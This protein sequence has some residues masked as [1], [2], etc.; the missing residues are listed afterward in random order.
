MPRLGNLVQQDWVQ[1]IGW[2][3][4]HSLWQHGFIVLLCALLLWLTRQGSA[5]LRYLIALVSLISAVIVSIL[6]FLKYQHAS[7]TIMLPALPLSASTSVLNPLAIFSPARINNFYLGLVTGTWILGV[8]V[9]GIKSGLAYSYCQGLKQRAS[10][11]IPH[12]W[13]TLFR[14]L[15][16]QVGVE[17]RAALAVSTEVSNPCVIGHLKPL[18]LLPMGLLT[19]LR[20]EQIEMILLHELAHIRRQDYLVGVA[21]VLIKNLFFFNPFIYWLSSQMD[22]ERE[23]ACDDIALSITPNPLLLSNTLKEL[24]EMNLNQP[25]TMNIHG[26]HLLL[27]RITRLFAPPTA[28]TTSSR[29]LAAVIVVLMVPFMTTAFVN[30]SPITPDEKRISLA[31]TDTRLQDVAVELNRVCGTTETFDAA[32]EEKISLHLDD[33]RCIDALKLLKDFAAGSSPKD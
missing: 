18:V 12:H 14:R 15:A 19:N 31:V 6:T 21:Q 28:H 3:L 5:H 25:F 16:Q 23:H 20:Y 24:A 9:C 1:S 2:T 8:L 4:I 17:S 30:A 29:G 26:R 32:A 27:Q 13:Q 33:T 11:Q 22:R 7:A 10:M